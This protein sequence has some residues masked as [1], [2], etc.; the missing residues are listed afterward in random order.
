ME[1]TRIQ[2]TGIQFPTTY[3][4]FHAGSS[5]GAWESTRIERRL[6]DGCPMLICYLDDSGKDPHNSVTTVAGYLARDDAWQAF[7]T[8][9]EAILAGKQVPVL[10]ARD[11]HASDGPFKGWRVLEK[12]ALVA[13][14]ATAATGRVMM[15]LSMSA[16]KENYEEH[17]VY[18]ADGPPS[19]RTVPP[20]VFCFQVVVDWLLRDIRVGRIVH[21]EGLSLIL[22]HGHENNGY[23]EQEFHFVRKRF[24]LENVLH[25]ISFA[26][27]DSC[28]AIQLA[29]LLAFYSRRDSVALLEAKEA[30]RE[31]NEH[32]TMLKCLLEIA[33]HRGF[34]ATGFHDRPR[35]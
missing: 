16:H 20:Y 34:V 26:R 19:R 8:D 24:N 5:A 9:A 11:L 2:G 13:R 25:T 32:E 3:S 27:K 21:A 33:P 18:R 31:S 1:S 12:Q 15:G 35:E 4:V 28:R 23:A 10:H 29:D 14:V 7:E 6:V 22:E 17:A 30:G